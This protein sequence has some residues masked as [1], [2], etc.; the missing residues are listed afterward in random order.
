MSTCSNIISYRDSLFITL[1]TG[2]SPLPGQ[3]KLI[4]SSNGYNWT[5]HSVCERENDQFIDIPFMFVDSDGHF[6]SLVTEYFNP[7]GMQPHK[8]I[9]FNGC[10]DILFQDEFGPLGYDYYRGSM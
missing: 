4:A 2:R 10:E 8:L 9:D 5:T 1:A 3:F 7:E 6:K